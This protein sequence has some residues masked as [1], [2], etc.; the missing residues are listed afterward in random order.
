MKGKI[1]GLLL[2]LQHC[3]TA[4][5]N[6]DCSGE[7]ALTQHPVWGREAVQT[8]MRCSQQ[9]PRDAQCSSQL[10]GGEGI[11]VQELRQ[12]L[13]PPFSSQTPQLPTNLLAV[14]LIQDLSIIRQHQDRGTEVVAT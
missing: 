6:L 1:L 2:L 10:R 8:H 12:C 7:A 3:T 14:A 4:Q 11:S 13:L 9:L 5:N